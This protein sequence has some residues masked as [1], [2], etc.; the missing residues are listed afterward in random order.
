MEQSTHSDL[1]ARADGRVVYCVVPP[2]LARIKPRLC[3]HFAGDADI[4]V[5]IDQRA[6]ERRGGPDDAG[7]LAE[8][9]V[10]GLERR[11]IDGRR[12]S[13]PVRELP[14]PPELRRYEKDLTFLA[15]PAPDAGPLVE[16]GDNWRDRCLAAEEHAR[17][18]AGTLISTADALR[19]RRGMSPRRYLEV[20]R[21]EAALERYRRWRTGSDQPG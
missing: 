21:A 4:E 13:V 9:L 18:L 12:G 10:P 5:V 15:A 6:G 17:S 20:A 3:E 2:R 1:A 16:P 7:D 8:R 19:L 11:A 14:L